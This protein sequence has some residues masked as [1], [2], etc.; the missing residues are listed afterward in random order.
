MLDNPTERVGKTKLEKNTVDAMSEAEAQI[1][2][3]ALENCPL[4]F[5]CLL[6]LLIT[7]G[8][9]RGELVGLKWRDIDQERAALT[10]EKTLCTAPQVVSLSTHRKHRLDFVQFL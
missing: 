10:V 6:Q 4:D 7:T 9:R 2:F 8:L 3:S 1:F 5:H